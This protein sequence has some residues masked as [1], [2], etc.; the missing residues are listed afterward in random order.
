MYKPTTKE[1]YVM[2]YRE[3]FDSPLMKNN[4]LTIPNATNFNDTTIKI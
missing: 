1:E 3:F 2:A 4:L